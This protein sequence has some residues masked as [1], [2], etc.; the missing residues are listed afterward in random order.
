MMY[1]NVRM[2]EL[3]AGEAKGKIE[4]KLEMDGNF[5]LMGGDIETVAKAAELPV[6]KIMALRKSP[7]N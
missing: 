3:L 5:L 2:E 4:G 1:D 7:I 6:E